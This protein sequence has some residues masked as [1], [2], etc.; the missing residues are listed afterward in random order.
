M[1]ANWSDSSIGIRVP[2]GATTGAVVVTAGGVA[3]NV[4]S[5]TVT[6]VPAIT[7]VAPTS[8]A[9]GVQIAIFGSGFGPS[10]GTGAV[11]LGSTYGTVASWSDTRVVATAA[12]NSTSGTARVQQ[13]GAW[14]NAVAF[15]VSTATISSVTP[16]SG[17][18]GTQVTIAGSGFGAAQGS[19]QVRLAVAQF[20]SKENT[21]SSHPARLDVVLNGAGPLVAATAADTYVASSAPSTN[22]GLAVNLSVMGSGVATAST[23]VAFDVSGLPAGALASEVSQATLFLW[24]NLLRNNGTFDVSQVTS[25][26]NAT[27]V[28]FNTAPTKGPVQGTFSATQV[29]QWFAVDVTGMAK[30]W[31]ANRATNFGI[32]LSPSPSSSVNVQFD[33]SENTTTKNPARLEVFLQASAHG[34]SPGGGNYLTAQTV[35]I[36]ATTAGASIR[37]TTDGSTPTATVGTVYTGPVTVSATTTLKAVASAS[38]YLDS[39]VATAVYTIPLPPP[40]I[41]SLSPTSGAVGMAVTIAG[42]NFGATQGSSTVTFGGAGAG[43]ATNWSGGTITVDVPGGAATGSVAVTVNGVASNP[44]SFTVLPTPA[45][46][47]LSESSGAVGTTVIVIGRNFG[48][49]QGGSAVTFNG[50]SAGTATSW[51]A[52]SITVHVPSGATSGAVVVTVGGVASNEVGFAVVPMP[53]IVSL[54]PSFGPVGTA[55]TIAGGNFGS[56]Q[57]GSSVTFNGTSAGT[58]TSWTATSIVVHVPS[59]ATAGNVVVTVDEVAG[60][61]VNFTV[62]PTPSI[63]NLDPDTGAVGTAVTIIGGNFGSMQGGSTVRFNG[64]S[65]GAATGWSD[66]SITV[67]VPGG[68]T[69][70]PVVVT[71]S[72]VASNGMNFTATGPEPSLVAQY[73]FNEGSGTVLHDTSGNGNEGAITGAT[74]SGSGKFGGALVFSASSSWVTIPDS[75]SLTFSAAMTLEAWVKPSSPFPPGEWVT[76]IAKERNPWDY[77]YGLFTSAYLNAAESLVYVWY[78]DSMVQHGN[79]QIVDGV[80]PTPLNAWTHLAMTYDS[81]SQ[82]LFVNGVLVASRPM[83]DEIPMWASQPLRIGGGYTNSGQGGLTGMIDE[84]RIYN[85]ALS[86]AEIQ[87]DMGTAVSGSAPTLTS[88]SPATGMQGVSVPVTLTGTN[89]MGGATVA[90]DNGGVTV[91]DVSVVS[92]TQIAATLTIAANATLGAANITVTTA[93]GTSGAAVF[94][95]AP[96]APAGTPAITSLSPASGPVGM[97]VAIAGSNFG[98]AQGGSTVTFGGI[99]AGTA[100]TW[101]ATGITVHV[102]SGTTSGAVVVTVGG[103]ASNPLNFTVT[104]GPSITAVSPA[105]GPVGTASSWRPGSIT[106]NVP[107]GAATGYVVVTL[108]GVASNPVSFTVIPPPSITSLNPA[109]GVEDTAV[110]ITGSN[111]GWTQGSGTV[112]FNGTSVGEASSWRDGSIGVRVPSGATTG[113]VVVTAGGMASNPVTFTVTTVPAITSVS[114]TSGAA[115]VQI[116]ISGSGF[117]PSRGTGAVWLGSTYGTVVSWSDTRVVATVA[118]NSTSGSARVQQGGAWSDAVAFNVSTATISSVTP[119]SGVPGTSVTI[120]GSGFGAAQAS[121]QVWLGT[122]NGVVQSWSDTQV[123]A[124]V[125]SG[126]ASGNA[127]VLQGGVLSNAVPFDVNTLQIASV[128][129]GSE[130]FG[131]VVM[132]GWAARPAKLSVGATRR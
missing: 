40:S 18:P 78:L 57:G 61:G 60:S 71:V 101:S 112:T 43:T 56:M 29:G 100:S 7:S 93:Y 114:P 45:I 38:G 128:S 84:V 54:N 26:W 108:N 46:T 92:T 4:V 127:Q 119:S 103:V 75:T 12:S 23:L 79:D 110:T 41:T 33:S 49:P 58:A 82:R 21:N 42:S 132:C 11:W 131:A 111:F 130:R 31:V 19:G 97:T 123:V 16:G 44:V 65:A 107:G 35:T 3:S 109:S 81:A 96:A 48:S 9:A 14:S 87:T 102:P 76:V 47:G 53:S 39:S 89:F 99:G 68:A 86:Q 28:T 64:T 73:N 8:G 120:A 129:P 124:L 32:E 95:V 88:L 85:R 113:A 104:P 90:A 77:Y 98:S 27:T 24:V 115:G 1:A 51:S 117:G 59:G 13:G 22:Y 25:P 10:R 125:A 52:T 122:A 80:S 67:N 69:T 34:F 55:V 63:A 74:W 50:T 126:S 37:Y 121:G 83:T 17:V 30:S 36:G 15:N 94:T 20:D 91:G 66:T 6:T 72:G 118:A 70:G 62:L 2:S 116:A 105:F 106:V 5:F